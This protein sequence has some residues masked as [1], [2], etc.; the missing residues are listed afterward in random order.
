MLHKTAEAKVMP[1][2]GSINSTKANIEKTDTIKGKY[3]QT[4]FL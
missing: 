4:S 2:V 1:F 3:I